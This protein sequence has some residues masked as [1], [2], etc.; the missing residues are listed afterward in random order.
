[1]YLLAVWHTE[2]ETSLSKIN[3]SDIRKAL[4]VAEEDA[5]DFIFA[6]TRKYEDE[7]PISAMLEAVIYDQP[8]LDLDAS[9]PQV[10]ESE[11]LEWTFALA[12]TATK[13]KIALVDF[14]LGNRG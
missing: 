5:A 11:S 9:I 1:M 3:K 14:M 8:D 4:E 6:A 7:F 10:F 2:H 13:A 12:S